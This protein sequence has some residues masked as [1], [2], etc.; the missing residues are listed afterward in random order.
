[1]GEFHRF[2]D[3]VVAKP[4]RVTFS[5]HAAAIAILDEQGAAIA[6]WPFSD[7]RVVDQNAVSG[8]YVLRLE[9]DRAAR[10]EVS[11]GPQLQAL[12]A[13]HPELTR[14]RAR[15]RT[16]L[17]KAFTMWG[18]IGLAICTVLYVG[19]S[20]ASIMI[21]DRMPRSWEE[22][23]GVQIE[24][25]AFPPARRCSGAEGL[26]ALQALG[27][28]IWPAG[29]PGG[30]VRL[31]VV[32]QADV[33]A[34][35]VPGHRI[36][37]FSGLIDHAASPEMVA[38]V[39]AHELGHVQLHHPMRGLIQQLGMGAVLTLI[40]G[41]SSLAG[42]GQLA[43]ALSYSRDMEREADQRGIALLKKAGIRADGMAAFFGV[44]K[45]DMGK[46]MFSKLPEFLSSHPDLDARIAATRQPATGAPAMSDDDWQ[47]LRKVCD[48][49]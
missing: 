22:K 9:P 1:M 2:F 36:V 24:E 12:L 25:A 49:P 23:I 35:A 5:I 11:A 30:P 4:R 6:A 34:F 37:V 45:A 46:G 29:E 32:K 14:W 19:W 28:R 47:A 16:G 44:I 40:F 48:N 20:R 39:I 17:L 27:D 7:M 13:Q 33:N 42:M 38:G 10:L 3:G 18:A 43:L 31:F 15:E 41:D 26:W 8:S 21:A